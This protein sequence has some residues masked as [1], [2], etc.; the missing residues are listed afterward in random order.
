MTR[1]VVGLMLPLVAGLHK[2]QAVVNDIPR[3]RH[4]LGH[5]TLSHSTSWHRHI[6]LHQGPDFKAS[7]HLQANGIPNK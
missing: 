3:V 1:I 2:V 6:S 4:T 5:V 7:L